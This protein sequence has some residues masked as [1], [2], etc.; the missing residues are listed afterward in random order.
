MTSEVYRRR[1]LRLGAL[2]Y[3]LGYFADPALRDKHG[4]VTHFRHDSSRSVEVAGT[5]TWLMSGESVEVLDLEACITRCK[6][7]LRGAPFH[8]PL[9][10]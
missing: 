4:Q 3:Q 1:R 10:E 9:E 5:M 8:R 7:A 2:L 6:E